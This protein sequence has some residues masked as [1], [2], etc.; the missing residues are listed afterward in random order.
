M[1][2]RYNQTL[3]GGPVTLVGVLVLSFLIP[4]WVANVLGFS[5]AHSQLADWIFRHQGISCI[6]LL[7]L[8]DLG[9]FFILV[10][11][12]MAIYAAYFVLI[13]AV[14]AVRNWAVRASVAAAQLLW[15]L[16]SWPLRML[17]DL[18]KD[19][20]RSRTADLVARWRERQELW[21]LYRA[22]YTQDF[23]SYRAFLRHWRALQAA[24]QAKT[25]PLQQAIR[26]IGLAEPFTRDALKE[27]F[28]LLI[29]G[30]HPDLV[31]PNGLA[32]QLIAA[33]TL[34]CERKR[35]K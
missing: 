7:L 35:W 9:G 5:T 19:Q 33:N 20:Y 16:L 21:R 1:M 15:V 12:G 3:P 30:I 14:V 29:G 32:A 2:Y 26:L 18:A 4:G 23:P 28:H 10:A 17:G 25:D 13:R 6:A 34:I 27:R 22:E 24:E 11:S 31:G 8:Y